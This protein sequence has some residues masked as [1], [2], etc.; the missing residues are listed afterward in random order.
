MT[1]KLLVAL[2]LLLALFFAT[3]FYNCE[4]MLESKDPFAL[5]CTAQYNTELK[6]IYRDRWVM[7]DTPYWLWK[8]QQQ[9]LISFYSSAISHC[10]NISISMNCLHCAMS[11]EPGVHIR[12]DGIHCFLHSF[13]YINELQKNCGLLPDKQL[14]RVAIHYALVEQG[15]NSRATAPHPWMRGSWPLFWIWA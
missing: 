7:A 2:Q 8:R 10:S 11:A 12:P 14:D 4:F 5:V 6:L 13:A 3:A 9:M 15:A 1:S